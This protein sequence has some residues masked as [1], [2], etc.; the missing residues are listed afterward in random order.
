MPE[1]TKAERAKRIDAARARFAKIETLTEDDRKA[2]FSFNFLDF[3][4]VATALP[5]FEGDS[6]L[7]SLLIARRQ[8]EMACDTLLELLDDFHAFSDTPDF[9]HRSAR[10]R[11][12]LLIDRIRKELFTV[13]TLAHSVQDHCRRVRSAWN[14]TDFTDR[15][16]ACF[17]DDGLHDFVIALR[18][19]LHH[20]RIFDAEWALRWSESG[21]KSSHINLKRDELVNEGGD[22]AKGRRWLDNAPEEIDV[23]SLITEYR[24]RAAAF[25][26]WLL[27]WCDLNVPPKVAEY[28]EMCR[29]QKA[30]IARSQW[31]LALQIMVG[32]GVDPMPHLPEYLTAE[33]LDHAMMLPPR[34][35][36]LADFVIG[37][38]DVYGGC[39][40]MIRRNAYKLFGVQ[41]EP[42]KV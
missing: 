30:W 1:D 12:D 35:H 13:S 41:D 14:P 19:G 29:R 10:H 22:W 5:G 33:E 28:R 24:A 32:K 26:D 16:A 17:G 7:E 39:D 20:Q 23:R 9:H 11:F 4:K 3:P 40:D 21:E 36:A 2:L 34:S 27:G 6:K 18:N 38:L 42:V 15:L 25:Y 31:S 37:C 8:F